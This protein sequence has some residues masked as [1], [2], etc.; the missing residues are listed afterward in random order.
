LYD[1]GQEYKELQQQLH[2]HLEEWSGV[3]QT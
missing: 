1:L 3:A 2:E